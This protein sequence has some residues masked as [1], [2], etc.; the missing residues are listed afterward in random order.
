MLIILMGYT[1]RHTDSLLLYFQNKDSRL[2]VEE[3]V[4]AVSYQ[5]FNTRM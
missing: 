2:T 1:Y 4:E 3:L 5:M